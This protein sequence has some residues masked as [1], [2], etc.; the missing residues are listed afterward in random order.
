MY[1]RLVRLKSKEIN[2]QQRYKRS[3]FLG[4]FGPKVEILDHYEKKLEDVEGNMRIERS[5]AAGKVTILPFYY[6]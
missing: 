3:G 2:T 6:W 5:S 1:R 4:L